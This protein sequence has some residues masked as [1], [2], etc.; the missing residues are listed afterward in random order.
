[1]PVNLPEKE[2][3]FYKSECFYCFTTGAFLMFAI[4]LAVGIA[5][6]RGLF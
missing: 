4:L 3:P 5:E 2:E 6:Q 1:V